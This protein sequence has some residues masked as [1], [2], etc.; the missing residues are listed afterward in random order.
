MHTSEEFSICNEESRQI[1]SDFSTE[2]HGKSARE[3]TRVFAIVQTCFLQ[4]MSAQNTSVPFLKK[5]KCV[6]C[7]NEVKVS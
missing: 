5:E 6:F 1:L 2:F 4:N 3:R 7:K